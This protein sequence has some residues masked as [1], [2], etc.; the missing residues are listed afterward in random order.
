MTNLSSRLFAILPAFL[1]LALSGFANAEEK[2][3]EAPAAPAKAEGAIKLF[4]GKTLDG[5]KDFDCGGSGEVKVDEKE[6]AMIIGFGE[7]L[8]GVIYKKAADL[9]KINYE[10]SLMAKRVDGTDF[11]CGLTFPYGDVKTC[12]TL[13]VGGWGGG[14]TGISSIG[15]LDASE[16]ET[17]DFYRIEDKKWYN[18]RL[19]VTEEKIEA[20]ID[21]DKVIDLE[22]KDREI[23]MRPGDIELYM[24][25]SITTF[26][27]TAAIKDITF[28]PIAKKD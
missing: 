8:T 21:K 15:G 26:Q 25:L 9:P 20:W 11:F 27:T 17:G 12:A 2:K 13:V 5:W 19:R 3:E 16:N 22:T 18:I 6:G 7:T 14:L 24:P 4:D 1:G 10:I 23:A 28:T